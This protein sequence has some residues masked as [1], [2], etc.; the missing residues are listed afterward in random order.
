MKKFSKVLSSRG[1]AIACAFVIIFGLVGYIAENAGKLPADPSEADYFR[2]IIYAFIAALKLFSLSLPDSPENW[3]LVVTRL[4]GSLVAMV[5]VFKIISTVFRQDVASWR[6]SMFRDHTVI[7]GYGDRNSRFLQ[8]LAENRRKSG[9]V[10]VDSDADKAKSFSSFSKALFFQANLE[11][12]RSFAPANVKDAGL[13][14]IGTGSDER[15]LMLARA[16]TRERSGR[17]TDRQIILTIDDA[18]L[19]ERCARDEDIAR[20]K[21]GDDLLVFNRSTLAARSLLRRTPFSDLALAANQ[22][23]VHLILA[24]FSETAQEV[25]IQFLRLSSCRGLG[26]PLIDIIAPDRDVV[27]GRMLGRSPNLSHALGFGLPKEVGHAPLAWAVEIRVH[28]GLP[29]SILFDQ[30]LRSDLFID[31]PTAF[32]IASDDATENVRT[33]LALKQHM[34]IDKS[35]RAPVFLHMPSRNS[36]EALMRAYDDGTGRSRRGALSE[37]PLAT[38]LEEV[39]EPFGALDELCNLESLGG[40]RERMAAILHRGYVDK[41]TK[42]DSNSRADNPTMRPWSE[43][44]ETYR[45]ASR[46]SIDHLPIKL[47]SI[48]A[49]TWW[50]PQSVSELATAIGDAAIME[51]LARLE[52]DSWRIDRELDG[53]RFAT[54]RDNKLLL[55]TDLVDYADLKEE[56][57]MYNCEIVRAAAATVFPTFPRVASKD[58]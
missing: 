20:P 35:F 25:V 52:H 46:R 28:A 54:A 53:W 5:A 49:K 47:L 30:K 44:G 42:S 57:R 56:S 3:L 17:Q 26:K 9:V 51:D 4:V 41:R 29:T 40:D 50:D 38:S 45:Q 10:V 13:V 48:G 7:L 19:A 24:G 6:A 32:V 1:L 55:H 39:I 15:N 2:L 11:I 23:R 33:G 37:M 21:N 36:L 27:I 31:R 34:Q 14:V 43:L 12:Q 16:V 18:G 58:P 8:G 22:P